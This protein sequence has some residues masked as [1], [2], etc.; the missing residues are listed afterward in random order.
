MST[1][2]ERITGLIF[3]PLTIY[4][5]CLQSIGVSVRPAAGPLVGSAPTE[6]PLVSDER[7][8]DFISECPSTYLT[9]ATLANVAKLQVRKV[10]RRCDGLCIH[11]GNG[12]VEVLGK[13]DPSDGNAI[14]DIYERSEGP[15]TTL[16][17]VYD[18]S[19]PRIADIVVG[20]RPE[21]YHTFAWHASKPG[22]EVIVTL[23]ATQ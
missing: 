11:H 20:N 8:D 17:F 6:K 19:E 4:R 5:S 12:L 22:R 7:T 9:R 10:G 21:E 16:T 3:D 23:A 2:K 18:K 1:N 15:L 14:I 13:W